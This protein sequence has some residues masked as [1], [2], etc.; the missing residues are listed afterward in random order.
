MPE[1]AESPSQKVAPWFDG[2]PGVVLLYR[3]NRRPL[4]E[5]QLFAAQPD[6]FSDH[7]V[8]VLLFGGE[9]VVTGRSTQ[10]EWL[11]GNR[12]VRV[13]DDLLI[14]HV[15]WRRHRAE[16]SAHFDDEHAQWIDEVAESEVS[17]RSAFVIDGR[18]Q[19]L[20]VIQH[21][22]FTEEV[23]AHVFGK[24]LERGE[25]AREHASTEWD[26]EPLLDEQQFREWV[27]RAD[28]VQELVFVAKLPNPDALEEFQVLF[29]R[30]ER[31]RAAQI[32]EQIT[33]RDK[34]TGLAEIFTDQTSAQF[35]A[36][37]SRA[38]GYIRAVGTRRGRVTKYDQRRQVKRQR[39]NAMPPTW[40]QLLQMLVDFVLK[41]R[42][43]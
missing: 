15:G 27:T 6:S 4:A 19:V 34:Q 12:E 7:L 37:A 43:G 32:R 20:A 8:E 18:S 22:T 39:V 10:R 41:R 31:M 5:P 29:D 30:M 2:R 1:D 28:A 13:A 33:A 24:I 23:L 25:A 38:Y 16:P 26:V 17:A 11:L 35:I 40:P 3:I 36:M 42:S 14:G 21:P 9:P